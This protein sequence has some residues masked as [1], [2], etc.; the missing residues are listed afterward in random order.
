ML[1]LTCA[2]IEVLDLVTVV[3]GPDEEGDD[4]ISLDL[5]GE[6]VDAD[7]VCV[8]LLLQ[9]MEGLQSDL[10]DRIL[11]RRHLTFEKRA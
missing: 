3:L 10:L 6:T 4:D 2:Q 8:A 5:A 1:L 11:D 7:L 9:V